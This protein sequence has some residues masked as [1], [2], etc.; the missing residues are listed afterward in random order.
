MSGLCASDKRS[1]VILNHF[2][3]SP[4]T[5]IVLL[6]ALVFLFVLQA[7][8]NYVKVHGEEK[9][10][11]GISLSH[12]QLFFLNFAQVPNYWLDGRVPI[13]P[14]RFLTDVCSCRYGAGRFDQ[15][16]P[17]I[18]SKWMYTVRGSSGE[19]FFA[20]TFTLETTGDKFVA[21]AIRSC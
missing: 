11:P 15:S 20:M 3:R 8:K 4:Q 13:F 2:A 5:V 17:S 9:L 14:P 12:D 1:Q 16:K 19:L 6:R 21:V 7:Y 10:L 18:Q